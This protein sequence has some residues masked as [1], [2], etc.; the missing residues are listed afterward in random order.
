MKKIDGL[1]ILGTLTLTPRFTHRKADFYRQAISRIIAANN[2]TEVGHYYHN[3]ATGGFT[4]VV[5]LC[6]SHVSIHT[7]P[8]EQFVTLDVFTCNYTRDN[9]TATQLV[10]DQ[11][12][13]LFE[14]VSVDKIEIRR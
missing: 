13:K 5:A 6:E 2:L 1:H 3:F 7:W 12:A 4:G 8:E 9:T 11:I 10:F 14:P